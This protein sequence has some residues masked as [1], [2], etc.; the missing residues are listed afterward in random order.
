V[1]LFRLQSCVVGTDT[2]SSIGVRSRHD[3]ANAPN[4][5]RV[6]GLFCAPHD[7]FRGRE[8]HAIFGLR[9]LAL[10]TWA[11]VVVSI[12]THRRLRTI[13]A[14]RIHTE[15][16]IFCHE[17]DMKRVREAWAVNCGV[18]SDHPSPGSGEEEKVAGGST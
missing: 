7:N 1:V 5:D 15:S 3:D 16:T 13:H 18:E 11:W 14:P 6:P 17:N 10:P 9:Q 8:L 2:N 4:R 12:A